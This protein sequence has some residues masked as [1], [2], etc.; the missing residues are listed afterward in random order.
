MGFESA[1]SLQS[2]VPRERGSIDLLEFGV[3][4]WLLRGKPSGLGLDFV[5]SGHEV[6]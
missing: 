4:G 3:C 6:S 5:A 1:V 2:N